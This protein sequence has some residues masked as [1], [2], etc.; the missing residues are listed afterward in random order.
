[1]HSKIDWYEEI[2]NSYLEDTEK[3]GCCLLCASAEDGCLC[4]NCKCRKCLHYE[5]EIIGE[6]GFCLI[7]SETIFEKNKEFELG[8]KFSKHKIF[9]IKQTTEKAYLAKIKGLIEDKEIWIPRSVLDSENYVQLWFLWKKG[10]DKIKETRTYQ[11]SVDE[12][13]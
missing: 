6:K 13:F 12:F 8:K 11:K 7:A 1:M 2:S 3:S 9:D 5:I 4:Y 10:F